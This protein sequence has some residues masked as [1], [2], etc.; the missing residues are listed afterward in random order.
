[1]PRGVV[2]VMRELLFRH[3]DVTEVR[4]KQ[5]FTG[6]NEA[7]RKRVPRDVDRYPKTIYGSVGLVKEGPPELQE[8]DLLLAKGGTRAAAISAAQMKERARAA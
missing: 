2:V 4:W 8:G 3:L 5:D 1:M 6:H 7:S